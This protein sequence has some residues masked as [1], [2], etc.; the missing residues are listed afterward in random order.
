MCPLKLSLAPL[1][2]RLWR[3]HIGVNNLPATRPIQPSSATFCRF[4]KLC[5]P[6]DMT[7]SYQLTLVI[8]W[9]ANLLLAFCTNTL[10]S[11]FAL[12]YVCFIV[13]SALCIWRH[14]RFVTA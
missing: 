2:A 8:L 14:V 10:I 12:F 1:L 6:V 7:D 11:I 3:R 13:S 4:T 9:T 5:D